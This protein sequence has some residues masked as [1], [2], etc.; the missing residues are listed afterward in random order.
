MAGISRHPVAILVSGALVA[1]A[2]KAW[3]QSC[4]MP[5]ESDFKVTAVIPSRTMSNPDAMCVLP[6]GEMFIVE[7]WSGK[8]WH[9]TPG[10]S[11]KAVG[12]V[13]TNAGAMVEDGMLGIAADLN[14]DKTHWLYIYHTPAQ[15]GS[16]QLDR[17][18]VANEQ[19][20]NPK[21]IIEMPRQK[22]PSG[23]DQ[24]HAGGG[25]DWNRRTG[26]LYM[27]IGDDTY[28]LNDITR[29][30][31]RDPKNEYATALRTAA[32]SNDLRG[33]VLRIKPIP[34]ADTESPTPGAGKT[35]TIPKGNLFPE[36]TDKTR[37]E[38]YTMGT[39]NAYRVKVDSL[40]GWA[41]IGEVGADADDYDAAKGPPGFDHIYLAKGPSNFGWPFGNGDM[42]PYV[43]RD[44][45]TDY[46]GAGMKV[47]DKFDLAHLKNLSKFNTG[48]QDLPPTTPPL[49]YYSAKGLQKGI[50]QALGGGS[51]TVMIGP[52]YD[53]NPANNSAVKMPPFFHRKVIFGDYSRHYLWLASVDTSGKL[54]AL[55]RIKASVGMTD[56]H[57]GPDGTIYLL[58]YD[59][60][61]VN[62]IQYT[63]SQ[64]DYT[65]CSFIK[66]GCTNP[67]FVEYDRTANLSKP[68]ACQ[69]PV[70]L[71]P[72]MADGSR[73]P[74]FR[75]TFVSGSLTLP[76][77]AKGAEIFDVHGARL[78]RIRGKAG[79]SVA[80]PASAA[81]GLALVRYIRD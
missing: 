65:A 60:G 19:L 81:S 3:S 30:G 68:S 33:K 38:I 74:A 64:K 11:A 29:W 5:P 32:N 1:A 47:G 40:T 13:P 22:G 78:A 59:N 71:A 20:T 61:G 63:G 28:P 76:A 56:I 15:L 37:P 10:G 48:I 69:T 45:E 6:N 16:T 46:I 9:Y 58:D 24:R 62:S 49:V 8:V 17:Y 39:R 52:T 36:G 77:G 18:T 21:K 73:G 66:E 42:E 72:R 41:Y 57:L 26:D 80:L 54:T 25:L 23:M 12:T 55:N 79:E 4:S 14:W 35:Y 51:E 31:P 75:L 67:A 43:V 44:Y 2:P 27:A 50:S 7:Q 53:F 70:S 34:F